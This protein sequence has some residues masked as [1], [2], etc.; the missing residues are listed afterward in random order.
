MNRN[1]FEVEQATKQR[2]VDDRTRA[3][4]RHLVREATKTRATFSRTLVARLGT[5]AQQ[6]HARLRRFG[7]AAPAR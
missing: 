7:R 2:G 4:H 5:L 6:A 3:A 1:Y